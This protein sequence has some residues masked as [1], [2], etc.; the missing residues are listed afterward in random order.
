MIATTDDDFA[1]V[2][3]DVIPDLGSP[4]MDDKMN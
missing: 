2:V 4:N 1:K 3:V